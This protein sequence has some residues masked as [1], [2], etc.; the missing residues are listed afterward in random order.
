MKSEK[1]WEARMQEEQ[2]NRRESLLPPILRL[3][4][5]PLLEDPPTLNSL[6]KITM[7][8][9][10]AVTCLMAYSLLKMTTI[11]KGKDPKLIAKELNQKVIKARIYKC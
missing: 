8:L 7:E 1:R 11:F 3:E 9:I 4:D 10:A 5:K 2:S 6:M